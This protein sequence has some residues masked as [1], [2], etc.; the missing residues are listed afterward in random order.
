[1]Y[2]VT[3][4]MSHCYRHTWPHMH[5]LWSLHKVW[6][7]GVQRPWEGTVH[8]RHYTSQ[9]LWTTQLSWR[10]T[11]KCL[12]FDWLMLCAWNV[13]AGECLHWGHFLLLSPISVISAVLDISRLTPVPLAPPPPHFLVCPCGHPHTRWARCWYPHSSWCVGLW[14]FSVEDISQSQWTSHTETGLYAL[15]ETPL[16]YLGL[17]M[18]VSLC[19]CWRPSRLKLLTLICPLLRD[20]SIVYLF[21]SGEVLSECCRAIFDMSSID[22]TRVF[23]GYTDCVCMCCMC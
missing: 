21:S 13:H 6:S 17:L 2:T 3:P 7:I 12:T 20:C 15:T 5:R 23:V 19:D 18:R 22:Y 14:L 9:T 11:P 4:T 16:D 10:L 8:G 1:M